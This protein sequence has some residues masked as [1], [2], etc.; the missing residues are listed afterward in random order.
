MIRIACAAAAAIVTAFA[1]GF[2]VGALAEANWY[3]ED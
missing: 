2:L 3:E 1:T